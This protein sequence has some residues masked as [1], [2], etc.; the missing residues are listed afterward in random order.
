MA[1]VETYAIIVLIAA[2]ALLAAVGSSRVSSRTGVPAPAIFLVAA[3]AAAD[4]FPS[5][6]S[7]SIMA[8]QRI[9]TIAQRDP[10]RG[11]ERVGRV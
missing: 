9:V 5:L 8:D 10:A 6:G 1:D 7:L 11:S 3:S 4:L 2:L